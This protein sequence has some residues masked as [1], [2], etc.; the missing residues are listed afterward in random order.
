M[1]KQEPLEAHR[2]VAACTLGS[3]WPPHWPPHF[4]PLKM[5]PK[6]HMKHRCSRVRTTA[7]PVSARSQGHYSRSNHSV[8]R[9]KTASL[10]RPRA[11]IIP[12]SCRWRWTWAS[13]TVRTRR[14]ARTTA[15]PSGAWASPPPPT[16]R[17]RTR[18]ACAPARG[19]WLGVASSALLTC[20]RASHGTESWPLHLTK[21]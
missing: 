10:V 12:N 8:V 5:R 2:T 4:L 16:S 18:C 6:A 3:D 15:R 13:L 9:K 11:P 20:R 14:R 1:S 17:S 21:R 19:R 7:R